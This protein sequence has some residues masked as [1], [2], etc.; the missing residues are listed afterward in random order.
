L[1][2]PATAKQSATIGTIANF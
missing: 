2:Q 1:L